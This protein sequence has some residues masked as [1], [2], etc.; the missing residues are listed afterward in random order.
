MGGFFPLDVFFARVF[1]IIA[2]T[3]QEG[4]EVGE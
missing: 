3:G 1:A 2:I 4:I